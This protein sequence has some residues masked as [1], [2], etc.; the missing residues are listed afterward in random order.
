MTH[1]DNAKAYSG[2]RKWHGMI[3]FVPISST[4]WIKLNN[5]NDMLN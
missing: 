3:L 1:Y 5:M 4:G 2:L